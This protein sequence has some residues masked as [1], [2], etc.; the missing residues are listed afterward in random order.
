MI[1]GVEARD[2]D[3]LCA[4]YNHYIAHTFITFEEQALS[5]ADMLARIAKVQ[6]AGLCWL[7]A[8][9]QGRVI[10]YAYAAP[11]RERAAYRHSVE[12]TVYVEP[13]C[14]GR[15]W[16]TR[17]YKALFAELRQRPVHVAIGGIALPNAHSI[18]LHEKLG[19]NQVARFRE[20]GFKFGQWIDVGYWQI[21][22][23]LK[24]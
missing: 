16:G 6:Q 7:V 5:S 23:E 13:A 21:E 24:T 18:A 19:M 10:A 22:F 12:V 20:V 8:E 3:A 9:E 4:I 17:L 14:I 15:G 11:W 1:R 2:A